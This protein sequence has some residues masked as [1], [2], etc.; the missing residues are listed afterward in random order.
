MSGALGAESHT[1]MFGPRGGGTPIATLPVISGTATRKKDD[2]S[3]A[4]LTLAASADCCTVVEGINPLAH[5]LLIFRG[6]DP[7]PWWVGPVC[8][9]DQDLF[10][11]RIRISAKDLTKWFDL[12]VFHQDHAWTDED[13]ATI[14]VE[15]INDGLDLGPVAD[16]PGIQFSISPTGVLY[17]TD[18][19]AAVRQTI[20]QGIR[21]LSDQG[22]DWTMI[23]R[24]FWAFR[25]TSAPKG[26]TLTAASFTKPPKLRRSADTYGSHYYALGTSGV[27]GFGGNYDP[28]YGLVERIIADPNISNNFDAD[29]RAQSAADQSNVGSFIDPNTTSS[30]SPRSLL[31]FSDLIPGCVF[32]VSLPGCPDTDEYLRLCDVRVKWTTSTEEVQLG[33]QPVSGLEA[34]ALDASNVDA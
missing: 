31:E 34:A 8:Q 21:S 13:L 7:D 2:T 17:S 24:V 18:V 19:R 27:A 16:N 28:Y 25:H 26:P 33:M 20:G 3:T 4:S 5:E 32:P 22:I 30:L 6:D 10:Q 23:G 9:I 1:V 11:N 29:N 15:M 14:M 12:R